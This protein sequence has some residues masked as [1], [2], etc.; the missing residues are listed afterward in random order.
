MKRRINV[1][2]EVLPEPQQLAPN[3]CAAGSTI[4]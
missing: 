1:A 2:G 3:L 4:A